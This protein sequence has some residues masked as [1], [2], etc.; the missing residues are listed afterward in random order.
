L[1]ATTPIPLISTTKTL[2]ALSLVRSA[3]RRRMVAA[4]HVPVVS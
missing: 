1:N 4:L 2:M 3:T